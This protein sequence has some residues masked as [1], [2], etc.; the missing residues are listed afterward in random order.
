MQIGKEKEWYFVLLTS[1]FQEYDQSIQ[2]LI[3]KERFCQMRSL[4]PCGHLDSLFPLRYSVL[5]DTL[6]NTM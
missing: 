2:K 5:P 4:G 3:L 6:G 1:S